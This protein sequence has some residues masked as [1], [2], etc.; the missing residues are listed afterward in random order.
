MVVVELRQRRRIQGCMG[1]VE[2]AEAR[3]GVDAVLHGGW[4]GLLGE[5]DASSGQ[6]Q[7]QLSCPE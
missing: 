1:P 4:H 5:L 3:T 7:T 2:D 6:T